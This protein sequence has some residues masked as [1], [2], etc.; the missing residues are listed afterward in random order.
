M[1]L[2]GPGWREDNGL[3]ASPSFLLSRW[4]SGALLCWVLHIKRLST[5]Y[6]HFNHKNYFQMSFPCSRTRSN[7]ACSFNFSQGRKITGI[8]VRS[9]PVAVWRDGK[10]FNPKNFLLPF[11]IKYEHKWEHLEGK[12]YHHLGKWENYPFFLVYCWTKCSVYVWNKW[13]NE[14]MKRI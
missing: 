12:Q 4:S 9:Y 11:I 10:S 6:V 3:G 8:P 13:G 1:L 2:P 5:N 14:Y 7:D